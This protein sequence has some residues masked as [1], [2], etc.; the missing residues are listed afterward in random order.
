MHTFVNTPLKLTLYAKNCL[1]MS[2]YSLNVVP[3]VVTHWLM[4][5]AGQCRTMQK[6]QCGTDAGTVTNSCIYAWA[7]AVLCRYRYGAAANVL[8]CK[9]NHWKLEKLQIS[10][11]NIKN[12]FEYTNCF[13][14]IE[15]KF[16][17][18]LHTPAGL[19]PW[20]KYLCR[21]PGL[22]LPSAFLW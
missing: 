17:Y 1:W 15:D 13:S 3:K 4:Y 9:V 10:I 6:F 5:E 21:L 11:K 14:L 8:P 19:L 20:I 2:K 22:C 18:A 7:S 12:L 16:V